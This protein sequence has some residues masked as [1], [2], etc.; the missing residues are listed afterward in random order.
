[1]NILKIYSQMHFVMLFKVAFLSY[2][3]KKGNVNVINSHGS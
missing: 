1:M 2:T 3:V